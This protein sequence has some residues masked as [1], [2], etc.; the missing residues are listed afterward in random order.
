[1]THSGA[2]EGET[3]NTEDKEKGASPFFPVS[4]TQGPNLI[5]LSSPFGVLLWVEKES[6]RSR[7]DASFLQCVPAPAKS[8]P[9]LSVPARSIKA[10]QVL[11]DYYS[12]FPLL[13]Q[14]LRS[15]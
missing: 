2:I 15:Q 12:P 13:P 8:N 11:P 3:Q 5:T 1:M 14:Y 4:E 7:S 10:T 6:G 9:P